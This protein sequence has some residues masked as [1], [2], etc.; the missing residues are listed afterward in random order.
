MNLIKYL[1]IRNLMKLNRFVLAIFAGIL[2][3]GCENDIDIN[4]PWKETPVIYGFLDANKTTQY[5]RVQKTYQNSIDLTTAEGAQISDSLYFKNVTVKVVASNGAVYNFTKDSTITKGDGFFASDV[6]F[7]YKNT[8]SMPVDPSKT[9]NLQVTSG[10]TGNT[11]TSTTGIVGKAEIMSISPDYKLFLRPYLDYNRV[12]YQ[13]KPGNSAAIYDVMIRFW[14]NEYPTGN[15]GAAVAKYVDYYLE[16]SWVVDA[17]SGKT[18]LRTSAEWIFYLKS[19][20]K[21][22]NSVTREF[23]QIDYVATGGSKEMKD[24]ID[25]SKPSAVIVQR[26]T[27]YSN[28]NGGL[29]IFSSRSETVKANILLQ[30]DSS[31]IYLVKDLPNFIY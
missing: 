29:G 7:I 9:Y 17:T 2:F 28:I 19:V 27:D 8:T 20:L 13:F 10:E 30:D 15:P 11:Y 22:D 3:A 14:Y 5:I 31:K 24:I 12:L 26:K 16:K 4:A 21:T 23:K 18:Y 25:L 1:Y 6:N